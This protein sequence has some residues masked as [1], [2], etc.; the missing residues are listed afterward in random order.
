MTHLVSERTGLEFQI[1]M[2]D[3][4][5]HFHQFGDDEDPACCT[6]EEPCKTRVAVAKLNA[7]YKARL[8]SLDG[9]GNTIS[10]PSDDEPKR[11]AQGGGDTATTS[12]RVQTPA[13]EKQV[14]YITKLAEQ[15]DTSNIGTFP[16]RT[17]TAILDGKAETVSSKRASSLIDVL[18]RQPRNAQADAPKASEKQLGFLRSLIVRKGYTIH[19]DKLAKL[20]PRDASELIDLLQGMDD[21][22]AAAPEADAPAKTDGLEDGMYKVGDTIYKVQHAVHGSGRQYAKELVGEGSDWGF[23]YAAGAIRKIRPEHRMTLEEAKEFGAL[24]GTCCVCGRT[25]TKESSIA[26]GIGPVCSGKV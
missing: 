8:A 7:E 14:A 12:G 24:Y 15:H 17:L 20:G 9:N 13:S 11:A 22:P 23:E 4:A 6:A 3:E 26:E 25:L 10:A 5:L 19:E 2:T 21:K 1:Q 16:A 18:R